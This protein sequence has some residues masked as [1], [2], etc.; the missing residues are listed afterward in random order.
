MI[1]LFVASQIRKIIE[2]EDFLRVLHVKE[3]LMGFT[4]VGGQ[5]LKTLLETGGQKTNTKSLNIWLGCTQS[6][7][8]NFLHTSQLLP[9]NVWCNELVSM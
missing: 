1:E 4:A 2:D 7:E 3:R 8:I 5:K 9:A 6:L